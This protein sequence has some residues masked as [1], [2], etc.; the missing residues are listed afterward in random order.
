VERYSAGPFQR[1]DLHR[2]RRVQPPAR[3]KRP[4]AVDQGTS[5]I[6]NVSGFRMSPVWDVSGSEGGRSEGC[7]ETPKLRNDATAIV[8]CAA[9]G[10]RRDQRRSD[11]DL[12]RYAR[13]AATA[14]RGGSASLV[15]CCRW[16]RHR[17][18]RLEPWFAWQSRRSF[19]AC[20]A[21]SPCR[22][23]VCRP[24]L[25]RRRAR[26]LPLAVPRV[27]RARRPLTGLLR[28]TPLSPISSARQRCEQPAQAAHAAATHP[29]QRTTE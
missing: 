2:V 10:R 29:G 11:G 3:R 9:G 24:V 8:Q 14:P 18:H 26:P 20:F 28:L 15:C 5:D 4:W 6:R 22:S 25:I 7:R 13:S 16:A 19:R 21:A 23:N 1:H 17:R 12:R 27:R